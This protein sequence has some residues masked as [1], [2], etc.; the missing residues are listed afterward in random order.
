MERN[1]QHWSDQYVVTVMNLMVSQ[2]Y[3][4]ES[5]KLLMIASLHVTYMLNTIVTTT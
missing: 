5:A 4:L 2:H 3:T 1:V